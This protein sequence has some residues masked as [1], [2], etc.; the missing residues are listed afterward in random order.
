MLQKIWKKCVNYET[1][2]YVICGFLTT[3]V[4]FVTY[5]LLRK[6]EVGVGLSQACLLYTSR[7]YTYKEMLE[8]RERVE[9]IAKGACMMTKTTV[10]FEIIG[11]NH[12]NKMSFS[13]AKL[14]HD[15]ME[16]IGAP[17][18]DEADKACLLYTS[19]CV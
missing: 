12:D 19:R 10:D 9:E 7:A 8:L 4:D 18:F 13:L 15:T 17:H 11:E 2:S 6:A 14:A 1:I 16:E 5:G 3:G